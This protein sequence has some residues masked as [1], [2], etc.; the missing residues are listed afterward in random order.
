MALSHDHP[1]YKKKL[2]QAKQAKSDV[3][4]RIYD[5]NQYSHAP[6]HQMGC[7]CC[8]F[9]S[10]CLENLWKRTTTAEGI[11]Y[12]PLRCFAEHPEYNADEWRART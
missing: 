3:L 6:S 11:Q 9:W 12:E 7:Y 8:R 2:A 10:E 1:A 4:H 5:V